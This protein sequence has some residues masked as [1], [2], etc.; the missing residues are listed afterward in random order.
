MLRFTFTVLTFVVL[1]TIME[2]STSIAF[3]F[4][5]AIVAVAVV[6][7]GFCAY[8]VWRDTA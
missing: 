1:F 3:G 7:A 5:W 4:D 8:R 2:A 6:C